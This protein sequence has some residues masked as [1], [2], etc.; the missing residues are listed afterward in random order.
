MIAIKHPRLFNITKITQF[1]PKRLIPPTRN[2]NSDSQCRYFVM[3]YPELT[4]VD[5]NSCL[6][7]KKEPRLFIERNY[8]Y[9]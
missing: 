9:L 4:Q 1:K 5:I 7:F 2:F 8:D 3:F 6:N